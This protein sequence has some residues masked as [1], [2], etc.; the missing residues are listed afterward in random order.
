VTGKTNLTDCGAR[1]DGQNMG[2][3]DRSGASDVERAHCSSN[4]SLGVRFLKTRCTVYVN[5][6]TAP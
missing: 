4:G 3:A 5:T 2:T 6:L 1:T